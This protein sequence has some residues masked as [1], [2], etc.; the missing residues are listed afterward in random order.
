MLDRKLENR[1]DS[2]IRDK[3]FAA[4][5]QPKYDAKT[6]KIVGAESLVRWINPDGSMVM[7]GDFIPYMRG[8][9]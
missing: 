1:F 7:P 5:F 8:M 4:Y 9:A 2:A 6:E 3:E